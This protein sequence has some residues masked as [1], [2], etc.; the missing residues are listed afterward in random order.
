MLHRLLLA[1]ALLSAVGCKED[2]AACDED[3][4]AAAGAELAT[5]KTQDGVCLAGDLWSGAPGAP[6]VLLLHMNPESNDR[7]N[8]PLSFAAD[9]Q[10]RGLHV[11]RLDRRGAG[12]SGGEAVD[13]FEGDKGRLDVAAGVDALL[14]EDAG[15]IGIIAASNGTTSTLDYAV[16]DEASSALT[17]ATLMTG[18]SYTENQTDMASYAARSLP[19]QLVYATDEAQWSVAQEPLDPGGWVWVEAAETGHGTNLFDESETVGTTVADWMEDA[20]GGG[21]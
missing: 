7:N 15:L 1:A 12:D 16:W 10:N 11:L 5:L 9:L 21:R 20:L 17:A 4:S 8:W 18:G 13:A 2:K 19:T 3:A 14:D 6:G